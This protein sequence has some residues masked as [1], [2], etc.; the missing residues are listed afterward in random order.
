MD[1]NPTMGTYQR[2]KMRTKRMMQVKSNNPMKILF[3]GL[4]SK[5]IPSKV[6]KSQI[7]Y[8]S[9]KPFVEV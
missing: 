3:C 8:E 4:I 6:S 2:K 7:P 1:F 9:L 5:V